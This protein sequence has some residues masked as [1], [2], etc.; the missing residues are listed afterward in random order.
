MRKEDSLIAALRKAE[1]EKFNDIAP[2]EEIGH[3]FSEGFENRMRRLIRLQR[4]PLWKMGKNPIQ[5]SILLVLVLLLTFGVPPEKN[6]LFRM[7]QPI[8]QLSTVVPPPAVTYVPQVENEPAEQTQAGQP[9]PIAQESPSQARQPN[10]RVRVSPERA[11][12]YLPVDLSAPAPSETAKTTETIAEPETVNEAPVYE[13]APS[14]SY[15]SSNTR[16]SAPASD[17]ATADI[18]SEANTEESF[19][20]VAERAI[21]QFIER[22]SEKNLHISE[23]MAKAREQSSQYSNGSHGWDMFPDMD[24]ILISQQLPSTPI[25]GQHHSNPYVSIGKSPSP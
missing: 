20:Q 6:P 1:S 9:D 19:E 25:P 23:Q 18:P 22:E 7:A 3:A 15:T 5:R 4:Q 8:P 10:A 21:Q 2:E 13:A 11:E 17:T 16:N 24:S 12:A 14:Y